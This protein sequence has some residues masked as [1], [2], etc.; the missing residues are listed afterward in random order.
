MPTLLTKFKQMLSA[1]LACVCV[2]VCVFVFVCVCVLC[3][4]PLFGSSHLGKRF[5][6]QL[7]SRTLRLKLVRI[8]SFC[9]ISSHSA[10]EER[11][12]RGS[13]WR[14]CLW[15]VQHF[16][17]TARSDLLTGACWRASHSATGERRSRGSLWI[18]YIWSVQQSGFTAR[19]DV[20]TGVCW[21]V[22]HSVTEERRSRGGLW[23]Q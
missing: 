5:Q 9:W 4:Y 20:L 8:V 7:S 15:S 17:F 11:R 12:S 2:C 13:L 22:S 3:V 21:R 14:Q 1:C 18:Q 10:T 16:G 19:S 23:T 6:V